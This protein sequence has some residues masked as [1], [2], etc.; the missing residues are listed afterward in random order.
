MS[1]MT[2]TLFQGYRY[3]RIINC[4]LFLD[5]CWLYFNDVAT[6]I[7]MVMHSMLCVTG[8]YL[9]GITNTIFVLLH[10]NVSSLSVCFSFF[11]MFYFMCVCVCVCVRR[12]V[13][14]G[15]VRCLPV[16]F[17]AC[18][19]IHV[20]GGN[21]NF[22]KNWSCSWLQNLK[23]KFLIHLMCTYTRCSMK[24]S[25]ISPFIKFENL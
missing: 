9:K 8:V 12:C 13:Y 21:P 5:S 11:A 2:L 3:V 20:E 6:H 10:F 14:V 22:L 24:G 23:E 7:K 19:L 18:S 15:V 1:L 4:K 25:E 16:S 17:G